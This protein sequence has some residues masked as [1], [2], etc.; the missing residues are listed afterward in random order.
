MN[1]AL[2]GHH[3]LVR[4]MFYFGFSWMK[5]QKGTWAQ[6]GKLGHNWALGE[7]FGIGPFSVV[8]LG[9]LV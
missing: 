3:V 7:H 5:A 8:G 9:L 6:F 4:L 1:R 2:L